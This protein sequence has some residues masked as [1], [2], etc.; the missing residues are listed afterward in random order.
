[1]AVEDV[2]SW[3]DELI[4]SMDTPPIEIIDLASA[5]DKSTL[6]NILSKMGS[7]EDNEAFKRLCHEQPL[8]ERKTE[9]FEVGNKL[10]TVHYSDSKNLEL[11]YQEFLSWLDDEL[12]LVGNGV[13]DVEPA[14]HELREFL[15]QFG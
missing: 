2:V 13:K 3:A 6:L 8:V 14:I 7:G 1:V 5:R 12:D 4:L 10:L 15:F 11:K 9:F